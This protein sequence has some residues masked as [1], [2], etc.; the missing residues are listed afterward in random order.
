MIAF[1]V[2][3]KAYY[4]SY[5]LGPCSSPAMRPALPRHAKFPLHLASFTT[6]PGLRVAPA[7]FL[8]STNGGVNVQ[9]AMVNTA[10]DEK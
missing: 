1:N 8:L 6:L 5:T 3:L 10:E 9:L 4:S 2:S 7:G